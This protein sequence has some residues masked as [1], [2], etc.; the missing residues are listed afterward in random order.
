[1]SSRNRVMR[2][3]ETAGIPSPL[4]AEYA[5]IPIAF[6]VTSILSAEEDAEGSF[7][8]SERP[9]DSPYIKDYDAIGHSP[10][11][12]AFRFDTSRW[13]LFLAQIDGRS[14]GGA[15]VA[16]GS[17]ELDMLEGRT[18]LAVL[19]DIRVAPAFRRRGVGRTLF[20]AAETWALAKGCRELKVE[21]QNINVRACRFYA[22]M[23][24]GL[25]T[26][27]ENAYPQC[28]DEA[29]WL[30]YKTLRGSRP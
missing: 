19:W 21:T 2:R 4:L 26:G 12:W 8:L 20:E 16:F 15:T 10:L 27:R 1:M 9:L 29:Q 23:G 17:S 18:D 22:A 13:V 28:P 30:W 11:E 6:E 24:C 7:I 25:R 5:T 14:V 3:I